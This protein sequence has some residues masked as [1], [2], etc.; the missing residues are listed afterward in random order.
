MTYCGYVEYLMVIIFI[1][2]IFLFIIIAVLIMI[3]V[4]NFNMCIIRGKLF[5]LGFFG[6]FEVIL[7]I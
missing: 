1:V 6:D 7:S 3:F 2:V 4:R 5:E